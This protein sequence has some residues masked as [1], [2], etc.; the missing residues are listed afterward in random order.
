MKVI[1]SHLFY[2][3]SESSSGSSWRR[4]CSLWICLVILLLGVC[5]N[6]TQ[7]SASIQSL[8]ALLT[9]MSS[10]WKPYQA[11]CC[12]AWC[13]YGCNLQNEEPIMKSVAVYRCL[14]LFLVKLSGSSLEFYIK[15]SQTWP[16]IMELCSSQKVLNCLKFRVHQCF[17]RRW[18]RSNA[19]SLALWDRSR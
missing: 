9:Y 19:C 10:H 15:R 16:C 6:L 7:T 11:W 5:V 17:C 2:L 1:S 3:C 8:L 14:E 12:P 18:D 4:P 13:R